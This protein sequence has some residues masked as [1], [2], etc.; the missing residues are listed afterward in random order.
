M[1]EQKKFDEEKDCRTF[2]QKLSDAGKKV[3]TEAKKAAKWVI[4]NKEVALPAITLGLGTAYKIVR[5]AH[6]E[7]KDQREERAKMLTTYDRSNDTYLRLRRQLTTKEK[8]ELDER[9]QLGQ[10]K[11]QALYQ[12]GLLK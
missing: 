1:E 2:R 10:T 12:M 3:K 6:A 11:T 7:A 4:D 5:T 8:V 9:M